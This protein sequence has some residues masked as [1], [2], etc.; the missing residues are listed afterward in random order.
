MSIQLELGLQVIQ[1][2]KRLSYTPWH[3]IAELVDNASQSYFDHRDALDEV[4]QRKGEKLTIRVVYDRNEGGL[5]R[6]TDNAMGMTYKELTRALR[7]G[8]PPANTSGRSKFGMGLKTSACWIGNE[9]TVRTKR[10]GE[11]VEHGL[12]VDVDEVASGSNI[13]PYQCKKGFDPDVHYTIVEVRNHNRVFQG[14]TLG[15]IRQF[16]RSMYRQDLRKELLDL[17]WQGDTLKWDDGDYSFLKAPDG[18]S[19][20][21]DF[22]F[23][24]NEKRVSGWVGILERGSRAKAGFS[25]LN[26]NRVVRGWPDSWRPESIY[27]QLQG[28]NNL[29]NQ[30]VIGEIHLD[31]FQVSHTKDDILWL[32]DEEDLIQDELYEQC[33]DYIQVAREHRRRNDVDDGPSDTETQAAIDE[34]ERELSSNEIQDLVSLEVVPDPPAVQAAFGSLTQSVGSREPTFGAVLGNFEVLGYLVEDGSVNDPYVVVDSTT[35][36][37]VMVVINT[38]HPHWNQLKGSDGV[39][40]Y[41]RHCTYDGIAEWQAR[42]KAANLDPAT[43]K[44]LK[45]KLLRLSMEIQWKTDEVEDAA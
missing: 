21:R 14:R 32:G 45:D 2:Y 10:L 41:F 5:L 44:L 18:S 33:A 9:W 13:L 38:L 43:I 22:E 29:V 19:Y 17:E 20:R 28:S 11:T 40:N 7:V 36:E 15:K 1:S 12:K 42:H 34:F 31:A 39:L 27:G 6:V 3:A 25:I 37:R 26:A 23:T 35:R 30:R 16:L 4:L 8:E 24:I